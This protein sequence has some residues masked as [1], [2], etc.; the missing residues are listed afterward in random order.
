V[1]ARIRVIHSA[2]R[3][4]VVHRGLHLKGLTLAKP[5][6]LAKG[7]NRTSES[8]SSEGSAALGSNA[9]NAEFFLLHVSFASL[10]G[11]AGV[12]LLFG[13]ANLLQQHQFLRHGWMDRD[14]LVEL[15]FG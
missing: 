15:L 10:A 1:G 12:I 13:P 14:A 9:L 5:A 8:E 7:E 11:V 6:K 4:V 2:Q 3:P